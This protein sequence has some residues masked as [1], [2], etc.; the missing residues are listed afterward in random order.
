MV[1]MLRMFFRFAF[2]RNGFF[3]ILR[4]KTTKRKTGKGRGSIMVHGKGER[5][6]VGPAFASYGAAVFA[7]AKTGRT[8][9]RESGPG[10][11]G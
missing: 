8:G 3:F 1:R 9:K 4:A 6:S 11:P 10:W 2:E 7:S 5:G